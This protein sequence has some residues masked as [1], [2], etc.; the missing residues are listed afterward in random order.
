M[1]RP[2]VVIQMDMHG[3]MLA[4]H[5]PEMIKYGIDIAESGFSNRGIF[6]SVFSTQNLNDKSQSH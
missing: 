2:M 4:S 1:N 5:L 3:I 6:A